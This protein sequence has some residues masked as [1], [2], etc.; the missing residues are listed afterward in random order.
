MTRKRGPRV[1]AVPLSSMPELR[2]LLE[3]FLG[4]EENRANVVMVRLADNALRRLDGLI[5]AGLFGSRSEAAAFLVGAG[6]RAQKDLLERIAAQTAE[7]GRMRKALR[8]TALDHL[9]RRATPAERPR[10]LRHRLGN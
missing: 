10:K 9:R 3:P 8:Q 1:V 5:E 6:I 4:G 7:I 2:K